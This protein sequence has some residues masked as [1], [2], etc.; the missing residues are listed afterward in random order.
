MKTLIYTAQFFE[1]GAAVVGFIY[2]NKVRSTFWKWFPF[3]LVLTFAVDF[4]GNFMP[5]RMNLHFFNN[6]GI[7][8]EFLFFIWLFGQAFKNTSYRRLPGICLVLY[9]LSLATDMIFIRNQHHAFYWFSYMVG[10]LLLLV[11]ILCYFLKLVTSDGILT[12][13]KSMMFWVCLGLLLF[14]LGTFPYYGL[15]DKIAYD[16]NFKNVRSTYLHIFPV[17]CSLM[18]LMFAI[19]FVWGTPTQSKS[20]LSL[21]PSSN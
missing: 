6:F 10:N 11:L 2:Y 12:F 1:A 4:S 5:P 8:M 14:Y 20:S 17:L 7:P 19:S 15:Y 3:Y 21:P 18:Y 13:W 9:L 16:S